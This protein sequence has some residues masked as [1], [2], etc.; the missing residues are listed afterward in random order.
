MSKAG[1]FHSADGGK[2]FAKSP[3]TL[4]VESLSFGKAPQDK[5]H[6]AL[7]AIGR[8]NNVRAISRSDDQ[9]TN[10]VRLNDERHQWGTRFRCIAADLRVFGRV[11]IGTD[12]RGILY[13]EPAPARATRRK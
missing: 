12:G 3:G 1:L 11:Y 4:Q 10:W 2:T 6:P 9:S 13:G 7:F 5:T 8:Q